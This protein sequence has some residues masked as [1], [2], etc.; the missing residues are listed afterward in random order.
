MNAS[1]IVTHLALAAA[2][3]LAPLGTYSPGLAAQTVPAV[4]LRNR[5]R[6]M[7]AVMRILLG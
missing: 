7:V 6:C 2:A 4:V 1:P 3:A 5:R